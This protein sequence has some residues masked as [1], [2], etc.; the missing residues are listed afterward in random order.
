MAALLSADIPSLKISGNKTSARLGS[1]DFWVIK[2]DANGNR[3]WEKT[4]RRHGR[5]DSLFHG[6]HA[7]GGC[8]LGGYSTS[9]IS[10]NKTTSGY[11]N[12]DFWLVKVDA[13]ANMIWDRTYGGTESE[14]IYG[15]APAAG[16]GYLIGGGIKVRHLRDQDDGEL[17]RA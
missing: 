12:D 15:I 17:R 3:V 4:F 11:G 1:S 8:L 13:T 16:G 6:H 5:R 9:D 14:R 2:L 10:G 7:D